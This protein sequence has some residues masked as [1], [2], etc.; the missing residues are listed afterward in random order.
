MVSTQNVPNSADA[1]AGE[2]GIGDG[3]PF[4]SRGPNEP[5]PR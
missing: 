3:E 1:G 4:Q 5:A 2:L